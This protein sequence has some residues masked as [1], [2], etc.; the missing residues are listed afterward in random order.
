MVQGWGTASTKVEHSLVLKLT[1]FW[2]RFELAAQG[3][4]FELSARFR[5][6]TTYRSQALPGLILGQNSP[7]VLWAFAPLS[8]KLA[9]RKGISGIRVVRRREYVHAHRQNRDCF[10]EL[11][12]SAWNREREPCR[13]CVLEISA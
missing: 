13:R 5:I 9:V 1:Q 6:A 4:N 10:G 3:M 12:S 2:L 11:C 7:L 8:R